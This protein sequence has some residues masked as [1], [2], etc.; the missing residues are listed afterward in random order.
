MFRAFREEGFHRCMLPKAFG[1]I[2]EKLPPMGWHLMRYS[3]K[4]GSPRR[5]VLRTV[6]RFRDSPV[7]ALTHTCSMS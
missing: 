5:T 4:N 3:V 1:G 6:L 2:A 7:S